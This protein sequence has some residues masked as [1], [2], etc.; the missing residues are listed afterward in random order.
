VGNRAAARPP[1]GR[2]RPCAGHPRGPATRADPVPARPP[3]LRAQA[4]PPG[5]P[6]PLR[7]L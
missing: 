1:R 4:R 5:A 3:R 6:A 2:P 7:A